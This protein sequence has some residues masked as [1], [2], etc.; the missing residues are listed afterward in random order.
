MNRT[1]YLTSTVL[2]CVTIAYSLGSHNVFQR[3]KHNIVLE[4]H[5][6]QFVTT[7]DEGDQVPINLQLFNNSESDIVV[8]K[9][10]ASCGCMEVLA[11]GGVAFESGHLL[12]AGTSIPLRVLWGTASKYGTVEGGV[13][14]KGQTQSGQKTFECRSIF[15]AQVRAR[16][17]A[18]PSL[19]VMSRVNELAPTIH[20][21]LLCDGRLTG[22]EDL[23]S[24]HVSS[25]SIVGEFKQPTTEDYSRF[26]ADELIPKYVYEFSFAPKDINSSLEQQFIEFSCGS[27]P[28]ICKVVLEWRGADDQYYS[29]RLVDFEFNAVQGEKR[30]VLLRSRDTVLEPLR[31]TECPDFVSAKIRQKDQYS[32]T[33]DLEL[34]SSV[35][36][37]L[38]L[39]SVLLRD[40]DRIWTLE[41]NVVAIH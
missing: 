38:G 7:F 41:V 17:R 27:K 8:N 40:G 36:G 2:V 12:K 34:L 37:Q 15:K 32:A 21:I 16:M 19:L 22:E 25:E 10:S 1:L 29:S 24:V 18:Y 35:A 4:P 30:C 23:P 20:R 26:S 5:E 14:V 31:V 13:L 28:S 39:H 11:N 9:V 33:V 3:P 6:L